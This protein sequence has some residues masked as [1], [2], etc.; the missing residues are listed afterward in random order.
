MSY[1][2][3]LLS[4]G[5]VYIGSAAEGFDCWGRIRCDG[6]GEEQCARFMG[7]SFT[8]YS[9]YTA[10]SCNMTGTSTRVDSYCCTPPYLCPDD[11]DCPRGSAQMYS[12][13]TSSYQGYVWVGVSYSNM[14]SALKCKTSW[15][16]QTKWWYVNYYYLTVHVQDLLGSPLSF[17]VHVYVDDVWWGAP[18]A[19]G[20]ITNTTPMPAGNHTIKVTRDNTCSGK[21]WD[22]W[23]PTQ[24][25]WT[26]NVTGDM[27]QTVAMGSTNECRAYNTLI[28]S[29]DTGDTPHNLFATCDGLQTG[30]SP[31][32]AGTSNN[33][34]YIGIAQI[35]PNENP[36]RVTFCYTEPWVDVVGKECGGYPALSQVE[37][38]EN[39]WSPTLTDPTYGSY[40]FK[41]GEIWNYYD[42]V[43]MTP[44]WVRIEQL[45]WAG[46][47]NLA[48]D[49]QID[50]SAVYVD[51]ASGDNN[52]SGLCSFA[53]A[54]ATITKA[55]SIVAN[56]GTIYIKYGNCTSEALNAALN[57]VVD[58]VRIMIRQ[59]DGTE[60][61][62]SLFING[63]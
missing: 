33:A 55:Q 39:T 12:G 56:N 4:T 23:A 31:W 7:P 34:A 35:L 53:N 11:P 58:N 47:P 61:T 46:R 3:D 27:T 42:G 1:Y 28:Y 18:D 51:C 30:G 57:P 5:Q 14:T 10:P 41:I 59:N 43:T 50:R 9:L 22:A 32:K 25:S 16:G 60:G 6:I 26:V 13:A 17:G 54:L 44:R 49:V 20:N 63:T 19:S 38:Y 24:C 21:A 48:T 2:S 15:F 45:C 36:K 8:V 29:Y 52:R 37:M 62:G 40:K